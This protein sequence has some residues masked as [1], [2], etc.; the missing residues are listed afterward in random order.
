MHS[1]LVVGAGREGKGFL[2]ETFSKAPKRQARANLGWTAGVKLSG[3]RT[4]KGTA[5][6][7]LYLTKNRGTM[8]MYV[9]I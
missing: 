9:C 3:K 6:W 2:G 4:R 1:I 8:T 5:F 7:I